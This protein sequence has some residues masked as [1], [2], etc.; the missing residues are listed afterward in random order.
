[1][2]TS[3]KIKD[4][5]FLVTHSLTKKA[6]AK[7]VE[8]N[9]NHI[10]IFDC[11]GSM[12]HDLPMIREQINNKVP[13]LA[14]PGDTVTLIWFSGRNQYGILIEGFPI[15]SA[16]DFIP[17]KQAV[18]RWLRPMG[19][20]GFLQPLKE[21]EGVVS[22]L[23]ANGNPFSMFFLT[24]GYDNQW[25]ESEI[26]D[27]CDNV[28]AHV[29]AATIVEYGYY[30][31][32]PLLT[33]MAERIG[34]S[35]IFSENFAEYEPTFEALVQRRPLG[36][37]KIK[38]EVAGSPVGDF[39]WSFDGVPTVYRL[40]DG[41]V[42]LIEGTREIA[43]LSEKSVG[44]VKQ[45]SDT[46][47]AVLDAYAG[48]AV[49]AQRMNADMVFALLRA[50]GD[51]RLIK[52]FGNCFGKQSY[53]TFQRDVLEAANNPQ[54]RW[55]EGYNPDLVPP[56]DA[57]TVLDVL[58]ILALDDGNKF[59]PKDRN[60]GYQRIGR[61][62]ELADARLTTAEQNE[63]SELTAKAKSKADLDK[64]RIRL[65]EIV[66]SKPTALKFTD[67]DANPGVE[68]SSLTTNATRP[69]ISVL[70]RLNGSVDLTPLLSDEKTKKLFKAKKVPTDFPSFVWRNYSVIAD[71][72]VNTKRLP[73]SLTHASFIEFVNQGLIEA[74]EVYE[75]DRIYLIDI[76][77]VPTINRKM[78]QSV[79]AKSL[80]EQS[81]QEN[82]LK[83]G[84]KVIKEQLDK[85]GG[86]QTSTGIEN[87]YGK[88]VAD[89]LALNG[90]TDKGF[91][92]RVTLAEATDVYLG[93]ELKTSIKGLSS[94]P[95]TSDVVA[96]LLKKKPEQL[97]LAKR[98]IA[99]WLPKVD[100]VVKT[101]KD[102][103]I[104]QQTLEQMLKDNREAQ[105]SIS[106][107]L[108]EQ[109]FAITVGKIWFQDFESLD[110]TEYTLKSVYGDLAC[111]AELAEKE[112]AR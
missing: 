105:R 87:Q 39:V 101:I 16:G 106:R 75:A 12:Y 30:C 36:A 44:T 11:S 17:L 94:L 93:R 60:F 4:D 73:V 61:K 42:T 31:N 63:I 58:A 98:L 86:A 76:S 77:H 6:E 64:V 24:D 52:Q 110:Q 89:I 26:L 53:S 56:E 15:R 91:S 45:F 57:F 41:S 79:S 5:L 88:E 20:T 95:K 14:K 33:K 23:K 47:P 70:V 46:C 62:A 96:D 59:Y 107:S 2:T 111:K 37:K 99:E 19:L 34:G 102:P 8:S 72:I 27:A 74:D 97:P 68:I 29:Q 104:R 38:V 13:M 100:K 40:A 28:G 51:A 108:N 48:M 50:T 7:P 67:A 55:T 22:R 103:K 9:S 83:A 25:R 80:F 65:D 10:F 85:D 1:M 21:V 78:V 18:D 90:I 84:N 82:Y 43:Y 109:R 66:S 81:L 112:F 32:R 3:Y 35:L 71:G 54:K 49:F 92:P 69:N